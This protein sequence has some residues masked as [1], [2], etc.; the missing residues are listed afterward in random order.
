M[1]QTG[2]GHGCAVPYGDWLRT[3]G[4]RRLRLG[5]RAAA[6]HMGFSPSVVLLALLGCKHLVHLLDLI[7]ADLADLSHLLLLGER[8]VLP[9][10][11]YLLFGL[12]ANIVDLLL[13]VV[14]EAEFAERGALFGLSG[15]SLGLLRWGILR[16]LRLLWR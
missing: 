6:A 7:A 2:R 5:L 16:G 14:R 13:L 8:G 3:A 9:N 10:G 15:S 11:L 1:R 4:R 12:L